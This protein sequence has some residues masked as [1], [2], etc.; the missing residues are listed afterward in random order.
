MLTPHLKKEARKYMAEI[1]LCCVGGE[2]K[3]EL[4]TSRSTGFECSWH[5]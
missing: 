4:K 5:S 2:G 3:H 1:T